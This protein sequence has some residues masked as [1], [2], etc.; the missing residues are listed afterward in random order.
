VGRARQRLLLERT[1]VNAQQDGAYLLARS[2]TDISSGIYASK[3]PGAS[4]CYDSLAQKGS[5]FSLA[6]VAMVG[7][8][9]PLVSHSQTTLL[10]PKHAAAVAS[11]RLVSS[12]TPSASQTNRLASQSLTQ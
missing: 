9:R 4:T 3:D 1:A 11:C 7:I 8:L 5:M 2:L 6:A 10:R 12:S